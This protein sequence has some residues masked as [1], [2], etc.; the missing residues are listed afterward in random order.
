MS[1]A[2]ERAELR[3]AIARLLADHSPAASAT[4]VGDSPDGYDRGLW[5]RLA[6]YGFLGLLIPDD[7]GGSGGQFADVAVLAE[8]MGRVLFPGPFISSTVT[9]TTAVVRAALGGDDGHGTTAGDTSAALLE[10][11]G[12]G[13]QTAVLIDARDGGHGFAATG[14]PLGGYEINGTAENVVG[15]DGAGTLLIGT[16]T[17]TGTV[18]LAVAADAAER[19]PVRLADATRRAATVRFGGTQVPASRVLA[20]GETACLAL[21][22]ARRC[23]VAA[24]AADSVG[25]ARATLELVT[26]YAKTRVQFGRPIGSFQAIK[27]KLADMYIAVESA[28]AIAEHAATVLDAEPN[29]LRRDQ[30][31]TAAGSFA[32]ASYRSVAGDSVQVHGGIG[33]TWEHLCH[34]YLKR[35]WLNQALM[36]GQRALAAR[37][38]SSLIDA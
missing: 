23:E 19:T 15:A 31:V 32:A 37:F 22:A 20:A 10:L 28:A 7:L 35:A 33:F 13:E 12:S 36:G 3:D 34:R 25:G 27:H 11:L 1:T 18:L 5:G 29:E 30:V 17:G 16:G 9:A 24:L 38:A 8:E 2:D 4:T 21:R 26:S 14:D 6:D